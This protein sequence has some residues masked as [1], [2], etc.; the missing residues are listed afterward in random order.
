MKVGDEGIRE[1]IMRRQVKNEGQRGGCTR[2]D[3][4]GLKER[5]PG[6]TFVFLIMTI[7]T[8]GKRVVCEAWPALLDG[9][10]TA[11]LVVR[12]TEGTSLLLRPRKIFREVN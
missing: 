4:M 11:T 8:T 10:Y 7:E 5:R 12:V 2:R 6:S 1:L 9:A 3:G